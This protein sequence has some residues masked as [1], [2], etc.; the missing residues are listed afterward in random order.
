MLNNMS[1]LFDFA[2]LFVNVSLGNGVSHCLCN[3]SLT[4][5]FDLVLGF[6]S[7]GKQMDNYSLS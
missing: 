3:F 2:L 1:V 4:F 7:N 6:H 5:F